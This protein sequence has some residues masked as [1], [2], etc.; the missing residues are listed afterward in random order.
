VTTKGHG[1]GE[2]LR[3]VRETTQ[4]H[5]RDLLV[6]NERLMSH[7]ASEVEARFADVE[8]ANAN[9]A[10]LYVASHSIHLSLDREHVLSSVHEVIVNLIG[11]EE[12]AILEAPP[13]GGL[14]MV[15]SSRGLSAERCAALMADEGCIGESIRTA[16]TW[17]DD[18]CAPAEGAEAGLT[19]CIPLEI[20]GR[21]L[22][23]IAIFRLLAHKDG[24]TALDHELFGLLATHAASA[25]YCSTLRA[26]LAVHESARPA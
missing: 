20:D 25:L 15:T 17:V 26:R 8:I 19:A 22:G 9:L 12:F 5:A 13:A 16:T 7:L 6:E 24:L 23:A 14:P 11:C 3:Q 1:I 21:V 10:N 18:G 4:R 2:Y